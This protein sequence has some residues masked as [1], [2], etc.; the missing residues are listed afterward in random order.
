M[1]DGQICAAPMRPL[2]M[3][4]LAAY[5]YLFSTIDSNRYFRSQFAPLF[6]A[7]TRFGLAFS[8]PLSP[9]PDCLDLAIYDVTTHVTN[10]TAMG[11]QQTRLRTMELH[12][13]TPE[14]F[15]V[16][17]YESPYSI[18]T[19][20]MRHLYESIENRAVTIVE[21]PTG[22]VSGRVNY[23][24]CVLIISSGQNTQS[25]HRLVDLAGR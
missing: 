24:F 15:P 2:S 8:R 1:G 5:V 17:P 21:S 18:Q 22:T 10:E 23:P 19:D 9:S 3:D 11:A 14:A 13:Q 20:L 4:F 6:I 12:L 7:R 16:F 25:A